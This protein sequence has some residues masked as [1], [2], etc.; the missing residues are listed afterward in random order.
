LTERRQAEE[1]LRRSQADLA[2]AARLS[3]MGELAGSIIHEINQ[4]LASVV[5]NGE[6]C[7]RWLNRAEPDLAEAREA[8]SRLVSDGRRAADVVKGLRALARKSGLEPTRMD[9]NAAIQ[10]ILTLLRGDLQ[11]GKIVLDL[12][13]PESD[14]QIVGDRIQLQQ[15]LLNLIRNGIEAMSD[16]SDRPRLL[17]ISVQPHEADQALV[18]VHDTGTGLDPAIAGRIFDPLFT[19]KS[20]GMGMGLSICRSIV[21]AHGGRLWASPNSAHGTTF[22]FTVPLATDAS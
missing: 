4:P 21:E 1:A 2:R 17:E 18:A 9:L 14:L 20:D 3:A 5:G 12:R 7:L 19:T 22:R 8:I 13:F 16:V 6:V 10:E 15:V 11:R